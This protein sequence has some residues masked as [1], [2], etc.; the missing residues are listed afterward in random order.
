MLLSALARKDAEIRSLTNKLRAYEAGEAEAQRA[1]REAKA[2]RQAENM[3]RQLRSEG[4]FL[5]CLGRQ[6]AG[7]C[8]FF[9]G[10]CWALSCGLVAL[11]RV[12]RR[13]ILSPPHE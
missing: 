10:A 5:S 9:I 8:E 13:S 3:A 6:A 11:P 2:I 7:P 4:E 12:L 1:A